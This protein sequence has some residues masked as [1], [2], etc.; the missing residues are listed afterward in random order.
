MQVRMLT[1]LHVAQDGD[2]LLW[3]PLLAVDTAEQSFDGD[4]PTAPKL[5]RVPR[6]AFHGGESLARLTCQVAGRL[7]NLSDQVEN[8]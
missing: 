6:V 8:L 4:F 3:C 1:L 2:D 5:V 7:V